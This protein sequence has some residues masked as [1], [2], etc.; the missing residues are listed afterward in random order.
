MLHR[1]IDTERYQSAFRVRDVTLENAAAFRMR[2][3]VRIR[4]PQLWI[5]EQWKRPN[6]SR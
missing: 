4:E 1:S 5:T 6:R 2:C 3:P